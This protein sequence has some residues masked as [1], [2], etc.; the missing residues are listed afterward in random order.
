MLFNS[1]TFLF[2]FLPVVLAGFYVLGARRREWALLWLIAASLV[3]CAWWRR[4]NGEPFA[5][6]AG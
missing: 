3:F 4:S 6:G 5:G 2:G 1:Y